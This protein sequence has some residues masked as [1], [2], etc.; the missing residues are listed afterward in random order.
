[1]ADAVNPDVARYFNT[2]QA[3]CSTAE[4]RKDEK[5]VESV[6]GNKTEGALLFMGQEIGF[7]YVRARQALVV[8]E[9]LDGALR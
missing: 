6:V 8:G 2:I 1:M 5:G 4:L 3:I 9:Q 7:D